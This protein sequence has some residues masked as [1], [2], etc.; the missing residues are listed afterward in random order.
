[1]FGYGCG[2]MGFEKQKRG[3]GLEVVELGFIF[4]STK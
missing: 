1:M 3:G 4:P 2:L